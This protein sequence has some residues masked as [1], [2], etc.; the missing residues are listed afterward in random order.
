LINIHATFVSQRN[1]KGK[2]KSNW[3]CVAPLFIVHSRR[4]G[5]DHTVLPASYTA[6]LSFIVSV[7]QTA[8]P[9]TVVADI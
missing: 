1:A 7:H 5:I 4:S 2:G 8:P 6:Y 9:L 3:I